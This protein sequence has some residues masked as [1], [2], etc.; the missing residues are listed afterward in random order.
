MRV[1]LFPELEKIFGKR[2]E[3]NFVRLG[4]MYQELSF[5]FDEKGEAIRKALI[6]GPFGF[7]LDLSLGFH[8]LELK[9]FLKGMA[10]ITHDA[11]EVLMKL[12]EQRRSSRMIHAHPYTFQLSRSHLFIYK[13]AFPDFFQKPEAWKQEKVGDW[14][15]FWKGE[16]KIPD[17]EYEI[18][19]ILELEPMIR[20]KIKKW[21]GSNQ[22]PSFFYDKAPIFI[23]NQ[24]VIAECLTGRSLLKAT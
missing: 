21:Y 19:R 18:K 3:G 13:E 10:P 7:Y 6:P 14:K 5:Y 23:R 8:P 22:V 11:L 20:K 12:I 2:M 15:S 4:K 16:I 24:E 17:G 1:E 9:Y